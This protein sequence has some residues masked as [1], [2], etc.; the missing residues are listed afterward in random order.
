[1][2]GFMDESGSRGVAI[3]HYDFFFVCL[4]I[5]K[6]KKSCQIAI[7][8]IGRVVERLGLAE[9]YEF[10]SKSNAARPKAEFLDLISRLDFQAI[11]V[12]LKKNDFRESASYR[13][14]TEI[15]VEEMRVRFSDLRIDMDRNPQLYSEMMKT[16][17]RLGWKGIKIVQCDSKKSRLIQVADYVAHVA[18]KKAK[19]S[20]KE[21]VNYELISDKVLE[22][23]IRR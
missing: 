13:R 2:Y 12:A 5:F 22:F 3:N 15:I 14:I 19:N 21:K 7:K 10:H 6:S 23:V 4:V 8:K 11:I 9:D 20:P 16:K 17:K 1:M 18:M